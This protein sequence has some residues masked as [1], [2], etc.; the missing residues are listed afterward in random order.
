MATRREPVGM[1]VQCIAVESAGVPGHWVLAAGADSDVRLLYLHGGGFVAGSSDYYLTLAARISAA[2][3]CA[4]LAPDYRLAPE[5]PFPAGLDDCLQSYHWLRSHAP[6]AMGPARAVYIAGDSAGGN[7][8]LS[9]L[10]ALRD[11]AEPL[12]A[13]AVAISPFADL[14]LMGES[15]RSEA[16]H[17]PIMSPNCLPEFTSRYLNGASA[18]DPLASPAFGDY[19]GLPPLLIQVGEHEI[20]RTDS[21]RVAEQARAAGVE[22]SLEVWN[23][24]F[25]VFQSHE[26]LLPE[27]RTAIDHIATFL[28]SHAGL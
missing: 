7:L 23:G 17:D 6:Q 22:V 14:T 26:P 27:A 2:A 13:A 18:T 24:L 15:L 4:V 8:T 3:G 11:R 16:P 25:H 20:I 5:H 9:M 1:D 21:V 28:R 12:P 19:Q 10:L